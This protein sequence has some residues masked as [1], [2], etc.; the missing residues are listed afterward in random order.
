[1]STADVETPETP[2]KT[3][4]CGRGEVPRSCFVAP[5]AWEMPDA[6]AAQPAGWWLPEE[7]ARRSVL[8]MHPPSRATFTVTLPVTPTALVF[9]VGMDPAAWERLGDGA[10]YRVRVNGEVAFDRALTATEARQGWWPGQVDLGLWAGQT[11][12]LTLETDPG[13]AGDAQGDW[14]GWGEVRLVDGAKA[15]LVLTDLDVRVV[16]AWSSGGLTEQ[17]LLTRGKRAFAARRFQEALWWFGRGV[18]IEPLSAMPWYYVG[19]AYE[20]LRKPRQALIAFRQ[21]IQQRDSERI[22]SSL[23]FHIGQ[24]LQ[25]S[26]AGPPPWDAILGLYEAA[27]AADR[28]VGRWERVGAHY[29]RGDVLRRMGRLQEAIEEFRWVVEERPEH[30]WGNVW[31]GVTLW[32]ASG[33]V[34]RAE[35]YL[36]QAIALK[37]EVKW[38]YHWLGE[39]Y[40]KTGRWEEA[41]IV[42]RQVLEI[43]PQDQVALQFLAEQR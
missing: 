4:Y 40:R 36:R 2:V 34:E 33:D 23:Y 42:Y 24:L 12:R 11:V 10:V 38:A 19:R 3:P 25:S 15:A 6:S 39:V 26:A 31:L 22:V 37:P 5:A 13:P 32:Q 1:L 35:K 27:L 8:F 29:G 43:D 14:A 30:Y 18:E 9:W 7:P 41:R 20:G 28:F 17:D 21:A 16:G